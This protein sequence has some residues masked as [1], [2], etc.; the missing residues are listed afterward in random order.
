MNSKI[1]KA[2]E[3]IL[4]S[5]FEGEVIFEESEIAEV[6]DAATNDGAVEMMD[7]SMDYVYRTVVKV[8][9]VFVTQIGFRE[10]STL[11]LYE[12]NSDLETLRFVPEKAIRL[13]ENISKSG[14]FG[15][16]IE[17]TDDISLTSYTFSDVMFLTEY[18]KIIRA[19]E[20]AQQYEYNNDIVE[21]CY[22]KKAKGDFIQLDLLK[23]Y[24]PEDKEELC[25]YMFEI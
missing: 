10:L 5:Y 3:A 8:N 22:L 2:M 25:D 18:G 13:G 14:V 12:V 4:K 11:G 24:L 20:Y 15:V 19:T 16:P 21:I 23:N 17:G 1:K 9:D 7:R 6:I